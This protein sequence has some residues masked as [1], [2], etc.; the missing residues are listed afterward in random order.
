MK[1]LGVIHGRFQPFHNDHLKYILEGFNRVDFLYIGITNPDPTLTLDDETDVKRSQIF[2][3]PC[4]FFERL[5][6]IQ[7]CLYDLD[8]DSNKYCI[9]PFPIN[10]PSLWKYYTPQHAKYFVAIYDEWGEK[11]LDAFLKNGLDT[12]VLWRRTVKEKGITATEIRNAIY[13]DKEWKHL[14]P[15]GTI[16]VI[17]ECNII[18]R[19]K[20]LYSGTKKNVK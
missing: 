16:R 13:H 10:I 18:D 14:V 7:N 1:A 12:E 6:M 20:I 9:V 3:N 8:I 19:I 15:N 17:E 11:K 5:R 4:T 2:A